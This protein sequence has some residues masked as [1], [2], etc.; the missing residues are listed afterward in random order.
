MVVQR[1]SNHQ[2]FTAK[3]FTVCFL[4]TSMFEDSTSLLLAYSLPL[5]LLSLVLAFS[6]TFLTL[7]RT[8]SFAPRSDPEISFPGSFLERR[9]P[10]KR[11]SFRLEGG[12]GGLTIGFIFG[13]EHVTMT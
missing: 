7:D 8:R 4:V 1:E 5:L 10:S 12:V 3:Y 9:K 6:G 2:I 11:W 13:C